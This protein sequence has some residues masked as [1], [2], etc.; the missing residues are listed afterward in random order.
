MAKSPYLKAGR[1]A[2]VLALIQVLALDEHAVRR[3]V[4]VTREIQGAPTSGADWYAVA[5]DHREFFRVKPDTEHGLSLVARYVLTETDGKRPA[6]EPSFVAALFQTAITLHDRAV[7]KAEWWKAWMPLLAA[8]IGS[9]FGTLST[10]GT[11]WLSHK[12]GW[13]AAG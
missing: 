11:L 10:L 6:L 9:I 7:S 4:G 1:L 13:K 12:Y 2:D 3:E 5:K 8:L